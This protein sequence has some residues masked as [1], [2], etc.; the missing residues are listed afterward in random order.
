MGDPPRCRFTQ[1]VVSEPIDYPPMVIDLVRL[2][3]ETMVLTGVDEQHHLL[4]RTPCCIVEFDPLTPIHG[5]ILIS[6]GN[7]EWGIHLL[8]MEE[9]RVGLIRFEVAPEGDLHPPLASFVDT[10][11]RAINICVVQQR[12]TDQGGQGCS[13]DSSGE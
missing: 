12:D 13:G 10:S 3:P 8:D 4:T 1:K 9:G 7:E 5:A 11:K 2:L 6:E